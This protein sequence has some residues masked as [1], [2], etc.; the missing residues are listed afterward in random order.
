MIKEKIIELNKKYP[1]LFEILR[2]LIVGGIATV[3]D[4][5]TMGIVLYIFNPKIYPHFYNVF[6]G[7]TQKP[8]LAAN[9]VGTGLGF[10]LGLIINYVLSVV[11]VFINKGNS[12]SA[13]GFISFA[14]LSAIGLAIHEIGMYVFCGKLG[15]NEWI[16]KIIMTLVVLVYNYVS[17][18]L[19]IFKKSA[20]SQSAPEQNTNAQDIDAQKENN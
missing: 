9:M 15:A 11:F 10:V 18:K 5:L 19:F 8:S 14:V 2:F 17:R 13:S 12:K 1:A 7:A 16:I 6:F 4:F 20:N 3:V